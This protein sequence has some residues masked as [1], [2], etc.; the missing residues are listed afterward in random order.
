M[1]KPEINVVVFSGGS[2]P[3]SEHIALAEQ[4]GLELAKNNIGIINGGGGGLMEHVAKSAHGAGGHVIGVHFEFEGQG[5]SKYNSKTIS[6]SV[7]QDRQ[8]KILELG[9]L[10]VAL[11]G[12]L[13][14]LYE[15]I[16]VMSLK[17]VGTIPGERKLVLLGKKYW[18]NF[19]SLIDSMVSS[20]YAKS[21]I[22][23]LY[24]TVDTVGELLSVIRAGNSTKNVGS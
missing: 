3:N 11:P 17:Y 2:A 14:T 9:E 5:K 22:K 20:G 4:L 8:K 7:L 1:Q 21:K 15:V 19:E 6:F 18:G 13:G 23:D 24:Q 12:G 16:D 10:Y